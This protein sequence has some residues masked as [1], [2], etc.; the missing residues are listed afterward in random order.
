MSGHINMLCSRINKGKAP[1]EVSGALNDL[2]DLMAF[3]QSVSGAMGTALQHL[4]DSSL[5]CLEHIKP[6]V[7]QDTWLQLCNALLF[8]Y[9]LFSDNIIC[10]AEQDIVKHD[11]ASVAPGPGPGVSCPVACHVPF[12]GISG[13]PQK[14]GV[15]PGP[16]RREMKHV[17]DVSCVVPCHFAPSAQSAPSVVNS[18]TVG[19]HLQKFWQVW[20]KLG[21]NPRVVS[22]LK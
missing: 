10:Q 17:K 15:S 5:S 11:S 3:H 1:K 2:K 9:G 20:E 4:A 12:A 7:K 6:G 19:G 21:S 16:M 14:K 8:G 22:I 13:P 18:L